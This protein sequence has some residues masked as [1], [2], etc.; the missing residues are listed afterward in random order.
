MCYKYRL[1]NQ[2]SDQNSDKKIRFYSQRYPRR[3]ILQT[4]LEE[5]PIH[6]L[7]NPEPSVRRNRQSK[8]IYPASGHTH[9]LQPDRAIG[10]RHRGR[11]LAEFIPYVPNTYPHDSTC[12]SYTEYF[13]QQGTATW[14]ARTVHRTLRTFPL[15]TPLSS[16]SRCFH[17]IPLHS[18]TRS[19]RV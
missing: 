18:S 15:I 10:H 5:H 19:L 17:T 4:Q 16:H 2:Y 12:R 1:S 3:S 14:T 9:A 6:T 8:R 11:G 7:N 13:P